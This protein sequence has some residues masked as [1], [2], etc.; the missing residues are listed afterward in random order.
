MAFVIDCQTDNKTRCL[1]ELRLLVKS[2]GGTVTSTAYL[3]EKRGRLV[4]EKAEKA[5]DDILEVIVEADVHD[6]ETDESG[7][8]LVFT[9]PSDTVMTGA[10]ISERT[11]IRMHSSN[12]IYHPI[13]DTRVPI[14]TKASVEALTAFITDIQQESAVQGIYFNAAQGKVGDQE[15]VGLQNSIDG[16][17][18][19]L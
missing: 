17:G 4:F 3:F 19:S 7:N 2:H 9:H 14:D 13:E 16:S 8:V 12:I 5:V 11:G 15:W 6:M 10:K 1:Q 18:N